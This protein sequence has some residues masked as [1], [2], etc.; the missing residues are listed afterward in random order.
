MESRDT[1]GGSGA[2]FI[3][4]WSAETAS[5]APIIEAVMVGMDGVHGLSFASRAVEIARP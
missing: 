1:S 2:N 4:E 3:V 5:E